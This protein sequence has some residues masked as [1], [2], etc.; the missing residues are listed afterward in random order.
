MKP[1][2]YKVKTRIGMNSTLAIQD[3]WKMTNIICIWWGFSFSLV[4]Q[5]TYLEEKIAGEINLILKIFFKII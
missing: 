5:Q 1:D 4:L 3:N 2:P